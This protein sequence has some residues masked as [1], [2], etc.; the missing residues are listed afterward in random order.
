MKTAEYSRYSPYAQSDVYGK[1][2]DVL[3]YRPIPKNPLD[4]AYY[5]DNVYSY[6]PDLL[7]ADL[8]GTSAL[9]WVFAVRN[10][11]VI[12]DPVFDF[13]EGRQIYIP[14][15]STLNTVLGI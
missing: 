7:A 11:D 12:K 6:R 3:T 15:Q 4:V 2:L 8:Y 10:P 13:V 1:F 14:N 9:W 5:I